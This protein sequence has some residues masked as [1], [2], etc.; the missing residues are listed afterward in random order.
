M[1]A[2]IRKKLARRKKRI[3]KRLD[4]NDLRGCSKPMFT[5]SNIQ[6]EIGER[7]RLVGPGL[8]A[9]VVED[10]QERV[11]ICRLEAPAKIAGGGRI[12]DAAGAEGVKENLVVAAQLDVLQ[13]GAVAQG[14]VGEVENVIR[15]VIRQVNLEQV[16]SA[17]DGLGKFEFVDE[18]V[19]GADAAVAEA[20]AT[21]ADLV[22][23]VAGGEHGLGSATKVVLVQAFLNPPLATRQL[24]AYSGV[25][26][27]ASRDWDDERL[28]LLL[29]PRKRRGFRVFS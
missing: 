25:H 9:D 2:R 28:A 8:L 15:L 5:A 16:Q 22:V 18:Q 7:G 1:N 26:S 13:T 12:G 6:Y 24:L 11:D 10:V 29:K 20:A 3:Q 27:K 14:V 4:K 17:I 21:L 19:H 23:D